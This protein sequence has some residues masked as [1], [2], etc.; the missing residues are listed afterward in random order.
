MLPIDYIKTICNYGGEVYVV[1]GAVRNYLYNYFHKTNIKIKDYDYLVKNIKQEDLSNLLQKIGTVKEVG[2]SFGIVLFKPFGSNDHIEFAIPRTEISTGPGYRDFITTADHTM[3]IQEDFS[4][5]DATINAIAIRV[6]N[7]GDLKLLDNEKTIAI[8]I[9]DFIDPFNGVDDIKNKVWRCVGNPSK[10]FL[11][12]PSRIMRAFRQSAE[13]DLTIE[14]DTM[15]AIS[16]DY[17]VMKKLIPQSYVRLYN[18]FF[19]MLATNNFE[20]NLKTMHDLG[21]LEFLGMTNVNVN[22]PI[23]LPLILKFAI[24]IKVDI[25]EMCIKEWCNQKQIPATNYMTSFDM[26]LLISIQKFHV[27]ISKCDSKYSMLKIVEKNYKLFRLDCYKIILNIIEYLVKNKLISSDK[28]NQL[29][30]YVEESKIYPP[31][32]DQIV[33]NGNLLMSKWKLKGQQI[34]VIKDHILNLIFKD[35]AKNELNCL[36]QIVDKYI[37]T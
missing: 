16:N 31:S 21:I 18:E 1:G 37:N 19:R 11:E 9:D 35:E 29:I 3:S 8:D 13:L 28:A 14:S 26:N 17:L 10:R 30:N 5:R 6:N 24:L 23:N 15:T 2:Q 22:I 25:I 36:E 27:E 12:D 4:R 34:K 32:T 7:L 20:R 33:L